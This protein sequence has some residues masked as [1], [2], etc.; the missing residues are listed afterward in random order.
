MSPTVYLCLATG[1][2]SALVGGV[3][4]SFSDF[5]MRGL[6]LAEPAG[7]MASM[8][9]LN[10]TVFR[11]AFLA[12]FIA[13]VPATIAL[14]I[15]AKL[16]LHGS[17]QVLLIAAA[18]VYVLLVFLVTAAGNVPM[19]E[20]LDDLSPASSEGLTYWV[21]YG[22]VWTWWNHVRTLGSIAT[23]VCLLLASVQ[24]AAR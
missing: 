9:A 23:A 21:T 3:F 17:P 14:G 18:I 20:R 22:R 15:H 12:T 6:L 2:A 24:L 10:R 4:Q 19:N 13:L 5:V 11:S 1:L 7:G 8:Q 16:N